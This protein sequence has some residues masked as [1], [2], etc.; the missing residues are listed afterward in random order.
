MA[1]APDPGAELA[2]VQRIRSGR[3][4]AALVMTSFSQSPYP[5]ASSACS[6]VCPFAQASRPSS[7]GR[8][9]RTGCHRHERR[10]IRPTAHCTCSTASACRRRPT[11][12]Y[13]RQCPPARR[14]CTGHRRRRR[15]LRLRGAAARCVVLVASLPARTLGGCRCGT[16]P[17]RL[18]RR[19]HRQ[20]QGGGAGPPGQRGGRPGGTRRRG[21]ARRPAAGWAASRGSH[22]RHEQLRRDAS[23]RRRPCAAGRAVCRHRAA[24]GV[25]AAIDQR[26]RA[27]ATD[28]VHAMSH[29]HL[30]VRTGVPRREPGRGGQRGN[31]ARAAITSSA[32]PAV[33]NPST[34][35]RTSSSPMRMSSPRRSARPAGPAMPLSPRRAGARGCRRRWLRGRPPARR[36]G[37]ARPRRARRL[38]E[39]RAGSCHGEGK[40]A[41]PGPR[42]HATAR[43][44]RRC[45]ARA[46]PRPR[47]RRPP[48]AS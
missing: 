8:F 47:R 10:S 38:R 46:A 23:R 45:L 28:V 40:P 13:M 27:A 7:V 2:L 26:H 36:P 4:D 19:R 12:G 25:R 22:R 18:R 11:G 6:P 16:R 43:P 29:I 30:P 35:T 44:R 37:P 32:F 15:Q 3:Y 31:S 5:A 24:R 1:G 48:R 42:P 39:G 20:R 9:S 21:G 34:S 41:R 14:G 33:G 17:R